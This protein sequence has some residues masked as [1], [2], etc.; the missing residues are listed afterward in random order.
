MNPAHG[1]IL[2]VD[3][4][5][6]VRDVVGRMLSEVGYNVIQ[7]R[8]AEEALRIVQ[9]GALQL[10]VVLTDVVL[11]GMFGDELAQKLSEVDPMLPILFMSGNSAEAIESQVEMRLGENFIRKPFRIDELLPFVERAVAYGIRVE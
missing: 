10:D 8:S 3:D 9:R 2:V 5:K 11:Q 6:L 1:N 7:A 4:E